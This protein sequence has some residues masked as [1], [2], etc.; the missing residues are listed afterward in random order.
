MISKASRKVNQVNKRDQSLLHDCLDGELSGEA[1][2][3]LETRLGTEL[4]LRRELEELQKT[5]SALHDL[6][7]DAHVPD[8]IWPGISKRIAASRREPKRPAVLRGLRVG[9]Y[10]LAAAAT[11]LI[12]L[13]AAVTW[14]AVRGTVGTGPAPGT[15]TRSASFAL[16]VEV[17]ASIEQVL[18][19]DDLLA[20][21]QA[22]S[23]ALVQVLEEGTEVLSPETLETVRRSL[24]LIDQAIA[25]IA[26]ALERD[27]G[28]EALS[29]I[30][31][32][33]MKKRL[34][35]LRHTAAAIQS[36]A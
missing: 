15:A 25:E 4:P 16:P 9:M 35:L 22:S 11:V 36:A 3:S 27:P 19:A 24:A 34:E 29:R 10:Q 12:V 14:F 31:I 2:A 23:D 8:G 33:N 20:G 21:Y 32:T 17:V 28:S 1:R 6:P 5:V 13:T 18:Q 7:K 26:E 30:V